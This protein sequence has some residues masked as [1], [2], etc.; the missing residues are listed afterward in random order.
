MRLSCLETL[1]EEQSGGGGNWKEQ[2]S[3]QTQRRVKEERSLSKR[4]DF[5][6]S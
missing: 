2:D 5:N 6:P 4:T 3:R 1:L